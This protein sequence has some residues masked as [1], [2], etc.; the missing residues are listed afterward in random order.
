MKCGRESLDKHANSR[1][2]EY[3]LPEAIKDNLLKYGQVS[4]ALKMLGKE[5]NNAQIS[6][7]YRNK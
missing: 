6:L 5:E 1:R 7:E 4:V 2:E 3:G